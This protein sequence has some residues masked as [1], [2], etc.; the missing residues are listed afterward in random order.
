MA[1]RTVPVVVS[2]TFLPISRNLRLTLRAALPIVAL[3]FVACSSSTPSGDDP[4]GFTCEYHPFGDGTA[5]FV[6]PSPEK[7]GDFDQFIRVTV[8]GHRQ[9]SPGAEVINIVKIDERVFGSGFE[10][11]TLELRS[12]IGICLETRD[13]YYVLTEDFGD[14][15]SS[16]IA[17][18][19]ATFPV[20]NNRITLHPDM[21]KDELIGDFHGLDPVLFK[22]RFVEFVGRDDIEVD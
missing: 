11:E 16:S 22:R 9:S 10:N 14:M 21:R 4:E 18:P 13:S 19:W 3:F 6:A 20:I 12:G 5:S 8:T 7:L 17:S 2:I 15:E 1:R